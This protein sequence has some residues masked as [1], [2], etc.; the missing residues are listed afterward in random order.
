MLL[1]VSLL[2][3]IFAGLYYFMSKSAE[4][5]SIE[6]MERRLAEENAPPPKQIPPDREIPKVRL[7]GY[8]FI[9]RLD[10]EENILDVISDFNTHPSQ[11]FVTDCINKAGTA[12]SGIIRT[13]EG[14]FRFL[15][16]N[17]PQGS[18]VFFLERKQEIDMQNNLIRISLTFGGLST[19]VLFLASY[20]LSYWALKP[21]RESWESQKQFVE[22]ASHELKTPLS[23]MNAN[24]DV[25]LSNPEESVKSQE[26][27]V[28]YIQMESRRMS[29]LVEN[30]LYLAK[31]ENRGKADI[32]S[33]FDL[34]EA[35][36]SVVL[37][38]ETVAFEQGKTLESDVPKALFFY[39]DS[40]RIKQLVS[41]LLDNAVKYSHAEG[42]IKITV[43][44]LSE[45]KLRIEV[46]NTGDPI[47]EKYQHKVFERFF[48]VDPSRTRTTGGVGLGLSIAEKIVASHGG[49]IR[50]VN[51]NE[52]VTAFIIEIPTGKW[53]IRK[54]KELLL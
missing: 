21:V 29:K 43:S 5:S 10:E 6:T 17:T 2:V 11:T 47:P 22:D 49:K 30:L 25:L 14:E 3:L 15:K 26:K 53:P 41:I 48:R 34:S 23:V 31:L 33:C 19:F 44:E 40:E 52:G 13:S 54:Q 51:E 46:A 20:F 18:S 4:Q 7:S 38:F 36:M 8:S 12:F 27:W 45:K 16:K 1:T 28:S 50:T 42:R 32:F 24:I 9:V 37:P 35:V 39:G